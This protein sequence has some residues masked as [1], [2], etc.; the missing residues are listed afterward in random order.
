MGYRGG[1]GCGIAALGIIKD[2]FPVRT[3][4]VIKNLICLAIALLT[5]Y[6]LRCFLLVLNKPTIKPS[7]RNN[8]LIFSS[9]YV[10]LLNILW[11]IIGRF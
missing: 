1:F 10:S 11:G 7:S 8:A 9:Y 5:A 2:E 4:F 6:C 3:A